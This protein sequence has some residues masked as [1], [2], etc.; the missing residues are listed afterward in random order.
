MYI[1]EIVQSFVFLFLLTSSEDPLRGLSIII[2]EVREP[3]FLHHLTEAVCGYHRTA[4]RRFETQLVVCVCTHT[5]KVCAAAAAAA[6]MLAKNLTLP[7]D[8]LLTLCLTLKLR[9]NC[10][11]LS[12]LREFDTYFKIK[13]PVEGSSADCDQSY[14]AIVRNIDHVESPG[15]VGMYYYRAIYLLSLITQIMSIFPNNVNQMTRLFFLNMVS[16]C[17][18]LP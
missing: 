7:I 15:N 6:D 13:S 12:S 3:Y 2:I 11:A 4:R 18:F 8:Q 17:Q 14:C 1:Q 9:Q 5:S 10:L 16:S